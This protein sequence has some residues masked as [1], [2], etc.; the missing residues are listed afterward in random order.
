M[1]LSFPNLKA[2]YQIL[3]RAGGRSR[4]LSTKGCRPVC[5]AALFMDGSPLA[6]RQI[7][8]TSFCPRRGTNSAA[9][10][11]YHQIKKSLRI[12]KI[13]NDTPS[14]RCLGFV[15]RK[16]RSR[17]QKDLS[18]SLCNVSPRTAEDSHYWKDLFVGEISACAE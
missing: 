14:F 7:L 10:P 18:C 16:R 11:N 9:T 6:A 12:V 13:Q 3:A 5:S 15:R 8:L 17:P 2:T 1:I 4:P